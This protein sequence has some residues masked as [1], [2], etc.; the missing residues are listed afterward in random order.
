MAEP[1]EKT[2]LEEYDSKH[3]DPA[4]DADFAKLANIGEGSNKQVPG[5]RVV[6]YRNLKEV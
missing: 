6:P 1:N 4:K 3:G 2:P 5:A